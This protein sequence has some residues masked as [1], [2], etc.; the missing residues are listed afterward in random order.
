M[1]IGL[2]YGST[3]DSTDR[4][5]KMIAA[6]L[7]GDI[8]LHKVHEDFD[9]DTFDEYDAVILGVPTYGQGS[10]QEDWADFIWEMDDVD[11]SGKK[12]ALFGLGDQEGYPDSFVDSMMELCEKA[13]ELGGEIVGAWPTDG[14]TYNNSKAVVDGKFLG[15]VIDEDRQSDL[16]E[17]RVTK[18]AA[19]LN[20]ELA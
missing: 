17:E 16:T 15:L 11:L 6:K 1:K 7:T 19:Q 2:F 12:V 4:V 9:A 14:Y 8:D 3:S 5:A 10:L 13:K 20:G 18:W